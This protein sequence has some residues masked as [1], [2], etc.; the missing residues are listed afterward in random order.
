[1]KTINVVVAVIK[2]H[3]KIFATQ[4]VYGDYK[5]GWAR[6]FGSRD[7]GRIQ[8]CYSSWRFDDYG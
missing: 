6:D 8:R 3:G 2:R 5:D 4:R 1:M 7:K